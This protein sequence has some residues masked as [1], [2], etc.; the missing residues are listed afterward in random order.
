MEPGE[1][2]D[3]MEVEEEND[4]LEKDSGVEERDDERMEVES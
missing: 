3:E 4:D 1:K 2:L